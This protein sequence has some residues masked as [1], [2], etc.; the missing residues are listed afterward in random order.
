MDRSYG[1][2]NGNNY[3]INIDNNLNKPTKTFSYALMVKVDDIPKELDFIPAIVTEDGIEVVVFDEQTVK[4]RSER[5][6]LTICGQFV[7][8]DMHINELRDE[9]GLN[10]VIEKGPWMAWSV[11]EISALASGLGKLILMDTMTAKMCHKRIGSLGFARVL[12]EIDAAKDL[13]NEI[14]IQ[15]IDKSNNIKGSKKFR[16]STRKE[17]KVCRTRTLEELLKSKTKLWSMEDGSK[18]VNYIRA[19]AN[20]YSILESLPEDNEAEL[21]MIKER[22]IVDKSLVAKIQPSVKESITWSNDMIEY[23]KVKWAEIKENEGNDTNDGSDI[24]NVI[25]INEGSASILKENVISEKK[26]WEELICENRFVDGKPWCLAGDLNITLQPNEHSCGSLVRTSDMLEF[27]ECLNNIE[28]EDICSSGL[29]YTW[30][31]NLQMTKAG[32]MTGILKKLD[33]VMAP[34]TNW[35]GVKAIFTKK[36]KSSRAQLQKV[37]TD[38]DID[39]FSLVLRDIE[40]NLVKEFFEVESDEEKKPR[41]LLAMMCKRL[42]KNFSEQEECLGGRGLRQ[43]YPISSYL[44]TL[45]MQMFSLMLQRQTERDPNFQYRYGC[46]QLKLVHVCFAEDLLV[47]CHGDSKSIRVIQRALNEFS[48]CCGLMPN[49]AKSTVFFR[50]LNDDEKQEI[51]D[52]LPFKAGKLILRYLRLQ[53]IAAVLESI[54]V[55]WAFVFL[56]QVTIIN[57]FNKLLKW[58]LWNQG[59]NAKGKAKVAW[60]DICRPKDQGGLRLKNLQTWNHTLL[61]KDLIKDKVKY[62]IG[63]G[64]E[65]KWPNE[66]YEKFLEIPILEVP[67]LDAN[68]RDNGG[69]FG[70]HNAFPNT[71]LLPDD[72][73]GL[74][75]TSPYVF[76]RVVVEENKIISEAPLQVQPL[77]KEFVDMIPVDIPLGLPAMRDIQ[78]CID[79]IPGSTIPNRPAYQMNP[80]VFAELQRQVTKL[81]EKGLIRESMSPCA[82]PALLGGRFTWTSEAAKAFDILKANVT[83]ALVLVL[84]NFNEVFQAECDAIGVGIGGVLSQNQ[85]SI[86]FFS[87]RLNDARC[88]CSTY[89]KEFYAIV[90]SLDTWRHYLLSNKFFLFSDHEALKFINGQHKL[91]SRHAKWIRVQGFDMFRGLYRDYPDFKETWSKCNNGSF[92]QFSKLDG[93]L[94]KGARLCI[95]LCS[96]REAIILEGYAGGLA[97]HF[98]R[99]KTLAL[100]CEHFYWPRM[101]RDVN[102]LL[103]RCRTWHIAKTHSSNAGLYNL[104][105]VPV[106]SWED[107]NSSHHPQIDVQTEVVNQSLGNLLR[108]LIEDNAKQWD[109]ILPQAEFTYNRS[110]NRTTV[111]QEQ[112][113]RHNEQYKEYADKHRKQVLHREGDLVWIH[114]CKEGFPAGRFGKLKPRGDGPIHVLKKINDSAYKIELPGHYNV[115]ATFNVADVL[116]YKED[117]DDEPDLGSSLFQEGDDDADAVNE[118]VNTH[119][120]KKRRTSEKANQDHSNVL[121]PPRFLNEEGYNGGF[122][123]GDIEKGFVAMKENYE[124]WVCGFATLAIGADVPVVS[125]PKIQVHE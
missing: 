53:L 118:R 114:L 96:L 11:K 90:R 105:S 76:T 2:N 42:F 107:L 21:K 23:F 70:S 98:G 87:E 63:N 15:Y 103:E 17:C 44:F 122:A 37:Q 81:L 61:A 102:R 91:K 82:V 60:K 10:A 124:A 30:T 58:F 9:I 71:P 6:C 116:P 78:H 95:P 40:A 20:K 50:S 88:K 12:V 68:D 13:K 85:Q 25:K 36:V 43:G 7:G 67:N 62:A 56:L 80:S 49:N 64:G 22:M 110:V 100:L 33:R 55:Y 57:E 46:K 32:N 29:H 93:Y 86:A 45:I 59:D 112:I 73:E 31:K 77:L 14:E 5:W 84:S 8:Y 3:N 39:P 52:I 120:L 111:G 89:D 38:I 101:E 69:F 35:H 1:E 24:E 97:G 113:I 79:F 106:A 28:V 109:L 34:L 47:M 65:W 119:I 41:L 19:S 108:S 16:A 72:F 18:I 121:N 75:E 92:Q 94:F 26:L 54:H 48:E 74:V 27:Q 104:L 117:I 125:H 115:F 123:K 99:D 51:L 4:L 66:W 83:E